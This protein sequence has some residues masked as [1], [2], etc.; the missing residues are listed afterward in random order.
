MKEEIKEEKKTKNIYKLLALVF[1]I[2]SIISFVFIAL[3]L[4][5][6]NDY[7]KEIDNLK[8]ENEKLKNEKNN[9][10][11]TNNNA[12][13]NDN[14][15]T[16]NNEEVNNNGNTNSNVEN[17]NSN[18]NNNV[19]NNTNIKVEST[20][21]YIDYYDNPNVMIYAIN[22]NYIIFSYDDELYVSV[23]EDGININTMISIAGYS[24]F[25]DNVASTSTGNNTIYVYKTNIK[26]DNV[27][28]VI[29]K[30]ANGYND[31]TGEAF[32][33]YKDNG[34]SYFLVNMGMKDLNNNKILTNYKEIVD[35]K[36]M[37]KDVFDCQSMKYIIYTKDGS[38]VDLD[39]IK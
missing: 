9:N 13:I 10:S 14:N 16:N 29:L 19:E 39:K 21:N 33:L 31:P 2:L 8:E 32:I 1:A 7:K 23:S 20:K 6:S 5:K 15:N 36:T 27:Y 4:M 35:I 26:T 22:Y 3:S 12:I 37:C 34:L 38:S 17:N 25:K 18:T 28:K 11:N 24:E 30:H